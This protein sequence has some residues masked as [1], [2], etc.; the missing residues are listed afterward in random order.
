MA[1]G[2]CRGVSARLAGW[3]GRSRHGGSRGPASRKRLVWPRPGSAVALALTAL[4]FGAAAPLRGQPARAIGVA[5]VEPEGEAQKYWTRWRGPSGQGVVSG[6]DYPDVWSAT[7]NVVWRTPVPGRGHSSPIVWRNQLFLT[8][9]YPDGRASVLA[10]DRATG[11]R[12]WETFVPDTTPERRHQKNSA[13]SPTPST[14]GRRVYASFGNQ[15]LVAVDLSGALVWHQSLG[16]FSNY[17]GTAGSPLLYKDRLIVYQDHAGGSEGGAFVAAFDTATGKRLWRTA[18]QATVGW[19]TPI[20]ARVGD[21]DEIIVS[22]QRVVVSY[23]PDSGREFWRCRGNTFEVI[24]TPVVGQGLVFCSSGRAGPTLAIRPG[25]SGDV[26]ETHV[27]WSSPRG[28]PFV[29]SPLLHGDYLYL[30]NDM[31]AV[32]TC[33]EAATGK[34]MWQGRLGIAK[35]EGFSASPVAVGD[36]VFFINDDGETFV[37]RAGPQFDLVRVNALGARVLASPALVDGRWYFRTEAELLAIGRPGT[38]R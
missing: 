4:A 29:P 1:A 14:D 8:T 33:L 28:S 12:L 5:M 3:A 23:D 6:G 37:V 31:T 36:K 13:A 18:R 38:S 24:P 20:A 10:F 27:E 35:P 26:T 17:H 7:E 34:L 25:G 9:A 2:R 16:T 30:V 21:R 32:A 22:G 15:G 19:G 11:R